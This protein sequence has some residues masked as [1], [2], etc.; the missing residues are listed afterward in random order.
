MFFLQCDLI[1]SQATMTMTTITLPVSAVCCGTSLI[2]VMAK[3]APTSVSQIT[4]GQQDVILQQELILK[5][6]SRGS[7]GLSNM[8]QQQ[9]QS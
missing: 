9:P 4:L 7:A 6:T 1:M 3:L 8:P 5:D 2:T